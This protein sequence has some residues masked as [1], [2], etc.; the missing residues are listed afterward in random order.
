MAIVIERLPGG[1]HLGV[2]EYSITQNDELLTTFKHDR[3]DDLKV[4]LE[5]AGAAIERGRWEKTI[6]IYSKSGGG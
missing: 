6:K 1:N 3:S 4:C 5:K 2:C